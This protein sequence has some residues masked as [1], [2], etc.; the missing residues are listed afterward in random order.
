MTAG[1]VAICPHGCRPP[2]TAAI[3]HPAGSMCAVVAPITHLPQHVAA[4]FHT[5]RPFLWLYHWR[6]CMPAR[7]GAK[8]APAQVAGMALPLA[9]R[10]T[11][12]APV[13]AHREHTS[14]FPASYNL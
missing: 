8:S 6:L 9:A 3:R 11:R 2:A 10:P 7:L 14:N 5:S 13:N 4:G 12:H 1:A